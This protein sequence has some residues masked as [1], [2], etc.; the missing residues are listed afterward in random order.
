MLG[1]WPRGVVD[2]GAN[3]GHWTRSVRAIWPNATFLMVEA[4]AKHRAAWSDLMRNG[5]NVSGVTTV[6]DAKEHDVQWHTNRNSAGDSLFKEATPAYSNL[7]PVPRRAQ[8]LDG[9]LDRLSVSGIP[10]IPELI[11]LDVQGAEL[12]VMRGATRAV[13]MADV[14]VMEM[15]FAGA[16]NSGAPRFSEYIAY[17]DSV[18]FSPFDIPEQHHMRHMHQSFILQIDM[19]F[20][21]KNSRFIDQIQ[22]AIKHL[23]G[24]R[25]IMTVHAS[26][27]KES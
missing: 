6:L 19:I 12:N 2:V 5:S 9:V 16:Y 15:P 20:V 22:K 17:L 10:L 14:I 18:G 7:V 11:K 3:R 25:A 26:H 21:R 4:N 13:S 23:S 24:R 27:N 8:T 1:F